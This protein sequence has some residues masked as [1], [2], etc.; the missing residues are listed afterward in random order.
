MQRLADQYICLLFV[1]LL[2]ILLFL[3]FIAVDDLRTR[4]RF[5]YKDF[6]NAYLEISFPPSQRDAPSASIFTA[7]FLF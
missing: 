6:N 7:L 5:I 2:F 4:L 1:F 3:L